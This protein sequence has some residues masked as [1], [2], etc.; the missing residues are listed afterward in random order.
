M[1]KSRTRGRRNIVTL[2][3][4][5]KHP[6]IEWLG[7]SPDGFTGHDGL[8]EIKNPTTPVHIGWVQEG[9]VPDQHKPQML[10]QMLC[11]RR[12][13]CDFVSYD[14]R[15]KN[16]KIRLFVRRYEPTPVEFAEI[17]SAAVKFLAELDAMFTQ[18]VEAA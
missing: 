11:T 18:I 1:T 12:G 10:L 7:C 6:H 4:F 13:W 15:I 16:A 5:I 9:N 8:V 17:E 2:V 3:G 14:S